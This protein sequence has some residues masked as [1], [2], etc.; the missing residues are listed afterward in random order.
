[1]KIISIRKQ[2]TNRIDSVSVSI[3]CVVISKNTVYLYSI[4]VDLV[5]ESSAYL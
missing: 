1:M 2:L 3:V 5:D 4:L